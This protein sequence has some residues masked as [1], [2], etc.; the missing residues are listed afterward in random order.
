MM[1]AVRVLTLLV[2]VI[3]VAILTRPSWPA[4]SQPGGTLVFVRSADANFLDPGFTTI[5]EDLDVG[6]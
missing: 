1:Q 3:A 2:A 4:P 6:V 5:T